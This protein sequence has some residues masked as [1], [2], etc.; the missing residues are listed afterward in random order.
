M[1][2]E[3]E[4]LEVLFL[5]QVQKNLLVNHWIKV[6]IKPLKQGEES[7]TWHLKKS[8]ERQLKNILQRKL[9]NL[10]RLVLGFNKSLMKLLEQEKRRIKLKM[11]MIA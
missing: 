7:L 6:S 2:T 8:G 3:I 5:F 4:E 10:T 1:E 11:K 9:K